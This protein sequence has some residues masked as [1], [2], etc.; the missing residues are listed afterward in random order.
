[1]GF[2]GRRPSGKI[3]LPVG[4]GWHDTSQASPDDRRRRLWGGASHVPPPCAPARPAACAACRQ[5]NQNRRTAGQGGESSARA[6]RDGV[7]L[8]SFEKPSTTGTRGPWLVGGYG[9]GQG[10]EGERFGAH[11]VPWGGASS[12]VPNGRLCV[13]RRP[14]ACE[15]R[16]GR[17][18]PAL[19]VLRAAYRRSPAGDACLSC[20]SGPGPAHPGSNVRC[21]GIRV[22]RIRGLAGRRHVPS[23]RKS[24]PRG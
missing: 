21:Q 13:A 14:P 8:C 19:R 2:P 22:R 18:P 7:E 9:G 12:Q 4:R 15:G 17:D 3:A 16:G 5:P 11:D 10:C 24:P 20:P 6:H 1:M 23:M